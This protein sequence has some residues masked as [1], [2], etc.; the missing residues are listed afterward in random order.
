M[1]TVK[2][3]KNILQ[4][5][6]PDYKQSRDLISDLF[7]VIIDYLCE[8]KETNDGT[9]LYFDGKKHGMEIVRRKNGTVFKTPWIM[10]KKH[11]VATMIH[12]GGGG[13]TQT[14]VNGK[15]HGLETAWNHD[16]TGYYECDWKDGQKHGLERKWKNGENISVILWKNGKIGK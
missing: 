9:C 8:K 11:G 1:S 4:D 10:G 14:W 3:A 2:Y 16:K 13:R 7:V 12:A 6:Y 15:E 5:C